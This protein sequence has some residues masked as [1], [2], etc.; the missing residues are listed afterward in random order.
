MSGIGSFDF[1]V[2]N[3]YYAAKTQAAAA[4]ATNA[5]QTSASST[6]STRSADSGLAPWNSSSATESDSARLAQAMSTTS[7]VDLNNAAFNKAGVTTDSKKLFALYTGLM[8]LQS[9]AQKA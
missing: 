4:R 7:F 1:S 6:S 9:L 5:S 3:G 8:S 2:L